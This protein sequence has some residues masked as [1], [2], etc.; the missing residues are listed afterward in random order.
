MT[1]FFIVQH[2]WHNTYTLLVV[3]ASL[4]LTVIVV[5]FSRSFHHFIP[6]HSI[7]LSYSNIGWNSGNMYVLTPE[8]A[9]YWSIEYAKHVTLNHGKR[10]RVKQ[11]V[12]S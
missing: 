9:S 6:L 8:L 3:T 7:P 4:E 5:M 11:G 10:W 12:P 1:F 2:S